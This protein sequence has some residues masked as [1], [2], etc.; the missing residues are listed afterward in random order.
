MK[1]GRPKLPKGSARSSMFTLRLTDED[2]S[3]IERA[4][5]AAGLSVSDWT[6]QRLITDAKAVVEPAGI[7]PARLKV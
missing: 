3:T 6:R 1:T 2:R 4:A 5:Q 7:E